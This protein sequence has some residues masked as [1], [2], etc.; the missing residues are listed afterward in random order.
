MKKRKELDAL[1]V[2]NGKL[3]GK[4]KKRSDTGHELLRSHESSSEIEEFC[5][6]PRKTIIRK[7]ART[8]ICSVCF[9]ICAFVLV[10]ACIAVCT[11]LVW[12]NIDLKKDVDELRQRLEKV[13]ATNTG[14]SG[15][16][17]SLQSNIEKLQDGLDLEKNSEQEKLLK[18]Q[19][20]LNGIFAQIAY[21]NKTTKGL[22]DSVAAA[23]DIISVPATV[24]TLQQSIAKLGS[25]ITG[26][27]AQVGSIEE[28][29]R[30]NE[31][32]VD[33]VK[34][35][36]SSIQER[37]DSIE[38]TNVGVGDQNVQG[39]A[40]SDVLVTAA[41]QP[42]HTTS[43]PES[44]VDAESKVYSN[45]AVDNTEAVIGLDVGAELSYLR[46][47]LQLV[48]DEVGDIN[49]TMGQLQSQYTELLSRVVL[50]ET[51]VETPTTT[52]NHTVGIDI[53]QM[54]D[55]LHQLISKAEEN[56]TSSQDSEVDGHNNLA[57]IEES[58]ENVTAL[59][60]SLKARVDQLNPNDLNNNLLNPNTTKGLQQIL[61]NT[62]NKMKEENAAQMNAFQSNIDNLWNQYYQQSGTVA[63][64]QQD[65]SQVKLLVDSLAQ[66][67]HQVRTDTQPN[68]AGEDNPASEPNQ[69]TDG[70]VPNPG[71]NPE[72]LSPETQPGN[73]LD[74]VTSKPDIVITPSINVTGGSEG[75]DLV[76]L[77]PPTPEYI[78]LPGITSSED[79]LNHFS[80]WD[81]NN[82]DLVLYADLSG[83]FG[84][85]LPPEESFRP[86]D[87]DH[88]GQYDRDE[89]A[90]AMGFIESPVSVDTPQLQSLP[91]PVENVE[92][93]VVAEKPGMCPVLPQGVSGI[94]MEACTSD[95]S[96]GGDTKC[97]STGCG[98]LCMKPTP[99]P[100]KPTEVQVNPGTC[101]AAV[102]S[103]IRCGEECKTDS[104]CGTEMKC[105]GNGCGH[106]CMKAIIE[107]V[108]GLEEK[109]GTCP[110]VA[111]GTVGVCVES[112]KS[113]NDC[114]GTGKCCSNG[115]GHICMT[116]IQEPVENSASTVNNRGQESRYPQSNPGYPQNKPAYPGNKP[117]FPNFPHFNR[118]DKDKVKE[119][120]QKYNQYK[121][122]MPQPNKPV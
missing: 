55:D 5:A 68:P 41:P 35:D 26:I 106:Q 80:M 104:E 89:L 49:D 93:Q 95:D 12:M 115:C 114:T 58:I 45:P 97:C 66:E 86:Y 20:D 103:N 105:C 109:P 6:A 33:T 40:K 14:N 107:P 11:G 21:L 79:L 56:I 85:S 96:C 91:E 44:Y 94:C 36:I 92:A 9:P 4:K 43:A 76:N 113:D 87:F 118:Q 31:K 13:E 83:F 48:G 82:D 38:L 64:I 15:E 46:Q 111:E 37:L 101:P 110:A 8:R 100:V 32:E 122:K 42:P 18:I 28:G 27:Q 2:S 57:K 16:L 24:Q 108:E 53:Q 29:E 52:S 99:E 75:I 71:Y 116:P 77:N 59:V 34:S 22:A 39:T 119:W 50:L 98:H 81:Q 51:G 84:P 3:H 63:A 72:I 65:V 67:G 7:P 23:S 88:N 102:T 25:D 1:L 10:V 117:A 19:S 78:S 70:E 62:A 69:P 112:C 54:Y 47:E 121:G 60:T 120:Q 73:P 17:G 30:Q 61:S 74:T 90:A